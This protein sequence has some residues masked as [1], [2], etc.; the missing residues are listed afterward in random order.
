MLREAS[1]NCDSKW[2][3][4]LQEAGEG[5][6]LT[7]V[8]I[9]DQKE[10]DEV[11]QNAADGKTLDNTNQIQFNEI[12]CDKKDGEYTVI[13]RE[14]ETTHHGHSH[15]HGHVHSPPESLRY[16]IHHKILIIY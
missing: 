10:D 4:E 13:I 12:K 6:R 9:H 1:K 16:S 8:D 14:H 3:S 15:A 7:Q 2:Y 11:R 5:Q